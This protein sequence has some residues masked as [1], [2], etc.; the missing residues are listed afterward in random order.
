[1]VREP[2]GGLNIDDLTSVIAAL[3]EGSTF[4]SVE[5]F[6]ISAWTITGRVIAR[7]PDRSEQRYFLKAITCPQIFDHG[8]VNVRPRQLTE[9][10][11]NRLL[12]ARRAVP[13]WQA[14]LNR[15]R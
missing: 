12:M 8:V 3:P 10:P 9:S 14:N 2:L 4:I 11:C 6:G 13:C 5:H 1:M 15:P 7:S